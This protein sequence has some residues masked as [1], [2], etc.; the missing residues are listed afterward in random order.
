MKIGDWFVQFL[1][2][3]NNS[4]KKYILEKHNLD[5]CGL[6]NTRVFILDSI[7]TIDYWINVTDIICPCCENGYIR[8]AEAGYVP[9]YRI[10]DKCGR[11][12]LARGN[13]KEPKLIR[14]GQRKSKF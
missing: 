2:I 9:G 13:I 8:W 5:G 12:F 10:C 11:H 6:K 3:R 7:S 4:T 1:E 14:V